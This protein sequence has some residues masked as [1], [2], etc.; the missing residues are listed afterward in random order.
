MAVKVEVSSLVICRYR[1][2]ME[3]NVRADDRLQCCFNNVHLL[4]IELCKLVSVPITFD[5]SVY[6]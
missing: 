1:T 4:T 6:G 3:T 5:T 2:P